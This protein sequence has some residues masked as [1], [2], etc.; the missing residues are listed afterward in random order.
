MCKRRQKPKLTPLVGKH[1]RA[2]SLGAMAMC[3]LY[4]A[5]VS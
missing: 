4:L 1:R 3:G 5:E 2:D